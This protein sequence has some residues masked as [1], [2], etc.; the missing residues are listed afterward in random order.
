MREKQVSV[1]CIFLFFPP[2]AGPS[3]LPQSGCASDFRPKESEATVMELLSF[4]GRIRARRQD[5]VR[6]GG[7]VHVDPDG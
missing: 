5:C 4:S 1:Q 3:L 7:G 6:E 2:P